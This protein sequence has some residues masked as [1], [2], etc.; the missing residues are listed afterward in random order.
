MTIQYYCQG[1]G[2]QAG[3]ANEHR[4]MWQS[5]S[6]LRM[7]QPW[8]TVDSWRSTINDEAKGFSRDQRGWEGKELMDGDLPS[9]RAIY[10]VIY[11][12]VV[13]VYIFLECNIMRGWLWWWWKWLGWRLGW[14]EAGWLRIDMLRTHTERERGDKQPLSDHPNPF[15]LLK[16][17]DEAC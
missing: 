16:F 14:A 17:K 10:K 13:C 9:S 12:Y 5:R 6:A 7:R 1:T 4:C 15:F 2:R 11:I 3:R 8:L